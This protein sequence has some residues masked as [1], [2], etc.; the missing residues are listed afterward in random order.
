MEARCSMTF[1]KILHL[2]ASVLT[3]LSIL[4]M[5]FSDCW[6]VNILY[7]S[8]SF[9]HSCK[10]KEWQ[11]W[12]S[13][14][15][16]TKF[17]RWGFV[18]L[19]NPPCLLFMSTIGGICCWLK[20]GYHPC[21]NILQYICQ[22]SASWWIIQ[23]QI[24]RLVVILWVHETFCAFRPLTASF[25]TFA[26]WMPN[27]LWAKSNRW[28]VYTIPLITFM[29]DISG[30]VLKQWNKHC[31]IYMSNVL[32]PQE[33][34]KQ[35]F[36][37]WFVSAS[38]HSSPMELV[39]GVRNSTEWVQLGPY[40]QFLMAL[41]YKKSNWGWHCSIW[42]QA[43]GRSNADTIHVDYCKQQSDAGGRV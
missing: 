25:I 24:Y 36:S 10:N 7:P 1:L 14:H 16:D 17:Q 28:T 4:S 31:V 21:F 40:T 15:L 38:P 6:W 2:L 26:N 39:Q 33:M 42:C 23:S 32:L 5:S 37:I 13:L 41:I 8:S 27:P 35:E 34:L 20:D 19:S 43:S 12:P 30:N 3:T 11:S 29:D 18:S 9:K 22:T